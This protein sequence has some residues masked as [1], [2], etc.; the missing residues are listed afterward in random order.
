MVYYINETEIK[1]KKEKYDLTACVLCG[2]LQA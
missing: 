1:S 2:N